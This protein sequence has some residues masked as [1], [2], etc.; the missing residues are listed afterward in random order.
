MNKPTPG[1]MVL[2]LLPL[3]LL[4]L[5]VVGLADAGY[6]QQLFAQAATLVGN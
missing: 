6:T 5:L 3:A 1:K 4:G 2:V